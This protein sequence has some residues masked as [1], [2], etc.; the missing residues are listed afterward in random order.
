MNTVQIFGD[1][2][3][4]RIKLSGMTQKASERREHDIKKVTPESVKVS[5]CNER[6][7]WTPEDD[8]DFEPF[9]KNIEQEGMVERPKV[10]V[11]TD[12]EGYGYEVVVGQRR[13]EAAKRKELDT[14]EVEVVQWD[15]TEALRKSISENIVNTPKTRPF[16]RATALRKY[17]EMA[18]D[19]DDE[20]SQEWY[21]DEFGV[22][23]TTVSRWLEPLKDEWAGTVLDPDIDEGNDIDYDSIRKLGVNVVGTIG[24]I[25]MGGEEGEWLVIQAAERGLSSTDISRIG[26][27]VDEGVDLQDAT[28]AIDE[29]SYQD[30]PEVVEYVEKGASIDNAVAVVQ[31]DAQYEDLAFV[32]EESQA[33][34][35]RDVDGQGE[36]WK[37]D[38]DEE[39]TAETTTQDNTDEDGEDEFQWGEDQLRDPDEWEDDYRLRTYLHFKGDFDEVRETTI[40]DWTVDDGTAHVNLRIE[41]DITEI[42]DGRVEL[43]VVDK[44]QERVDDED[45]ESDAVIESNIRLEGEAAQAAQEVMDDLDY[46][47][48]QEFFKDSVLRKYLRE[49]EF[50]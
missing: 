10:R 13:I 15:D 23:Q 27:L 11:I 6:T 21:A 34:S 18:Y 50:L 37:D 17:G 9:A 2:K 1:F 47:N 4:T 8:E 25:T 46:N 7:L 5:D 35:W 28:E 20:P 29:V 41:G 26:S 49:T 16:E 48:F 31:G 36:D 3:R 43:G 30:A 14:I 44:Q 45:E 38:P 19:D 32:A 33:S 22:S 40:K 42:E 12:E 24:K 39:E